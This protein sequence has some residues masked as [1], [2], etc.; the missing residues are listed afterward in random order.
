MHG[1]GDRIKSQF[2]HAHKKKTID[3]G[4]NRSNVQLLD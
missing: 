2:F 3:E 1:T 4:V